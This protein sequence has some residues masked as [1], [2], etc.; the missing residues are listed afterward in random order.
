MIIAIENSHTKMKRAEIRTQIATFNPA[1]LVFFSS[2]Y[3]I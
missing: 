1:I 3:N 2:S